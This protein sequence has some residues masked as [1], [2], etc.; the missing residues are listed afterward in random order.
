MGRDA[1]ISALYHQ[2]MFTKGRFQDPASL[3]AVSAGRQPHP[4]NRSS[5]SNLDM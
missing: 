1:V 5:L 3:L 2:Q 4:P